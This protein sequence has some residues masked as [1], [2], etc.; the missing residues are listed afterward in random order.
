MLSVCGAPALAATSL[1][2]YDELGRLIAEINP[3]GG[4]TRYTYDA[5]GN[6]L[7]VT[8][9]GTGQFRVDAF[10]PGSG[11]V[12]DTVNIFGAGF[13]ASPAQ[14]NVTFNGTAATVSLASS[15]ALIVTVPAGATSGPIAVSN[16]NGSAA[17]AQA[18]TVIAPP[19][20]TAVNPASVSRGATTRVDIEGTQLGSAKEVT[21]AETG[22]KARL[23]AHASDQ[24]LTVDL[25]VA[26]SVLSGTYGFSVTNYGGTTESGA[27]TVNVTT[28]VLGD[29][30]TATRPI[31]IH[32]P[33]AEPGAPAGN[34]MSTSTPLS[35]HLPAQIPGAPAGDA[36]SVTNP[37]SVSMP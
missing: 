9:D 11:K 1:Y 16:S 24:R 28:A 10:S 19:T 32:L 8:R 22:I 21:F 18:F 7:S 36:M 26:G 37:F 17:T 6:L 35:V 12:G 33:A 15:N 30:F 5:A 14:N 4:T 13:I 27:V 31:S 29:V 34:R 2:V 23:V 3:T 25:S 20:I